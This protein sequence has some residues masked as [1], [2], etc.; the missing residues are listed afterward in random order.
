M[1]I[2]TAAIVWM[3]SRTEKRR[4]VEGVYEYDGS[5]RERET[6]EARVG[7]V[8]GIDGGLVGTEKEKA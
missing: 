7:G 1:A 4:R 5:E 2:W 3:Q 8:V 6:K